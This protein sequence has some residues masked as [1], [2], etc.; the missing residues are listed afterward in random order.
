MALNASSLALVIS[1]IP[2]LEPVVLLMYVALMVHG[3]INPSI[4]RG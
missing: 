2:F 4:L 1:N 3:L